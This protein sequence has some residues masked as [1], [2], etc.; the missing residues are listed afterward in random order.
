[1]SGIF[2]RALAKEAGKAEKRDFDQVILQAWREN[3]RQSDGIVTPDSSLRMAAVFACARILS[4]TVA[5]LPLIT[6][7]RL[8]RGKRRAQDFYLYELLHDRPNS[9]MTA[10]P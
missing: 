8:E 4:E 9:R 5:S 1:M 7:E 2:A 3:A 6:Y 10:L